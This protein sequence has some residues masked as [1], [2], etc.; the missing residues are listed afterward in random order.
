[1]KD[2]ADKLRQKMLESEETIGR[3]IAVVSGKGGVGKS[4]FTT[5]FA[6]L[7]A[8]TGK[9]VII[10]DMD[11]G[12]GNVHILVGNSVKYSLKD[13]L[14][15]QMTL[16]DV[17]FK[18][19]EGVSYISGGSGMSSLMDW[20]PAIFNRLITAFEALQ[21]EYDFVFF[22][23]GAGVVDWSL[24]L[25]TS[26]EEII[27]ISTAE[28]TSIMDAYSMMKFIHLKD[29]QK[30][31]YLLCNRAFT[32]EEGIE[33]TQRLK[34]V[35]MKFLEKD[36]HILGSLPEDPVVRQAVRQQSLFTTI[37]PDAPVS[38]TMGKLVQQFLT[39]ET[40]MK[41]VHAS[42]Q[43]SKFLSKLKSIFSRGRG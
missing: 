19:E 1:M 2:Q 10:L 22:D 13:Y 6:T 8:K 26:I 14:D 35:M 5:N 30:K 25:L 3:S 37:Y 34:T 36:V 32:L 23:M 40:E 12:M 33:T 21:K 31:F 9:K 42:S 28:P 18:T 15:G 20:S 17:M 38:Q 43:S 4:N 11:I 29:P 24:D 39:V 27:V 7:L 16:E 41:E